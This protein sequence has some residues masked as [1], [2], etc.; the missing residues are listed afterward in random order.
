MKGPAECPIVMLTSHGFI[1]ERAESMPHFSEETL[2]DLTWWARMPACSPLR[3]RAVGA[4]LQCVTDGHVYS[5]T[6]FSTVPDYLMPVLH[7][8]R[9]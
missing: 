9:W 4:V 1:S 3:R 6:I 2:P 5:R 8:S 7:H